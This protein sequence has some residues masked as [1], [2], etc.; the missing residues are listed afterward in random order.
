MQLLQ[1]QEQQSKITSS[2][3]SAIAS[4]ASS[5]LLLLLDTPTGTFSLAKRRI[6]GVRGLFKNP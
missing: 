5:T 1:K 6:Y 4:R 2:C 3:Q